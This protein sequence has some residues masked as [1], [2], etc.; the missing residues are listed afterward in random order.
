[1]CKTLEKY[2]RAR[3]AEKP[4]YKKVTDEIFAKF[5]SDVEESI[6]DLLEIDTKTAM[7]YENEAQGFSIYHDDLSRMFD[8]GL[9]A[10][11]DDGST[12]TE[13]TEGAEKIR[14]AAFCGLCSA[15]LLLGLHN[16][17]DSSSSKDITLGRTLLFWAGEDMADAA[18]EGSKIDGNWLNSILTLSTGKW[19]EHYLEADEKEQRRYSSFC[20]EENREWERDEYVGLLFRDCNVIGSIRICCDW[21]EKPI[22]VFDEG[23]RVDVY[24]VPYLPIWYVLKCIEEKVG[25][26]R[27]NDLAGVRLCDV[28][29]TED[30]YPPVFLRKEQI[31]DRKGFTQLF[32]PTTAVVYH[33]AMIY[34]EA[35]DDV[36]SISS[37][38]DEEDGIWKLFFPSNWGEIC[39]LPKQRMITRHLNNILPKVAER[40]FARL[41][42]S[43]LA[44]LKKPKGKCQVKLSGE[45]EWHENSEGGYDAIVPYTLIK[46]PNDV[47]AAYLLKPYV[48]PNS[49]DAKALL[50]YDNYETYPETTCCMDASFFYCMDG[51]LY[52]VKPKRKSLMDKYGKKLFGGNM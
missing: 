4:R 45:G 30:R 39:P 6:E 7:N 37:C 40:S 15:R 31:G 8:E 38:F 43:V 33:G 50:Q 21:Y 52:P 3:L 26:E 16:L 18:D 48:E 2:C 10:V 9:S 12:D 49:D 19:P 5:L 32:L 27:M 20:Y 1:M 51:E 28:E 36:S 25:G 22:E 44:D 47:M 23:N 11:L 17:C 41:Y 29:Q 14:N 46:L 24:A 34:V 35:S 42:E 13:K